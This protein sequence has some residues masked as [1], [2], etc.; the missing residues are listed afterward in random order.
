[1][2]FQPR[3]HDFHRGEDP[4]YFAGGAAG[5][6]EFFEVPCELRASSAITALFCAGVASCPVMIRWWRRLG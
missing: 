5:L 4:P 1:M 3:D 6:A 2:G